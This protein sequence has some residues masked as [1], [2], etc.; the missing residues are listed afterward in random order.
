NGMLPSIRQIAAA[1][2]GL[3]VME[4]WHNFGAHYDTT[5]MHWWEN[6]RSAWPELA[7]RPGHR[8]GDRAHAPGPEGQAAN[9]GPAVCCNDNVDPRCRLRQRHVSGVEIGR[10]RKD[11]HGQA[12][13]RAGQGGGA[14]LQALQQGQRHLAKT[15]RRRIGRVGIVRLMAAPDTPAQRGSRR[16]RGAHPQTSRPR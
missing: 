9:P 11:T 12:N 2:E 10:R 4:D 1:T 6:V 3:F 16:R 7:D 14:V 8:L 5:L 15:E 13:R